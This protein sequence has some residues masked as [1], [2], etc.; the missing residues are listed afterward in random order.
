M[1]ELTH[2]VPECL[3]LWQMSQPVQL[4]PPK[5]I[6]SPVRSHLQKS[7]KD[8]AIQPEPPDLLPNPEKKICLVRINSRLD[9][10]QFASLLPCISLYW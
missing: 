10:G 8:I 6:R 3:G 7:W 5:P 9:G 4:R 1:M 2:A